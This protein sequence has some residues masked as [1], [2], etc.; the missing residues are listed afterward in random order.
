MQ[1]APPA[2]LFALQ[3]INKGKVLRCPREQRVYAQARNGA[4]TGADTDI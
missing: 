4:D 1:G 2:I 3:R